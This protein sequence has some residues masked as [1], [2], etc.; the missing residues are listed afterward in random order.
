MATQLIDRQTGKYDPADIEDRYETRLRAVID[1]KIKGEGLEP[2]ETAEPERSNVVDLMAAL[3]KSLG[4]TTEQEAAPAKK[5]A[6]PKTAKAKPAA[7]A[8]EDEKAP[9]KKASATNRTT[10]RRRA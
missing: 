10:A 3:R 1:A 9:A 5:A 8:K 4:Q 6:A 2:E 7:P